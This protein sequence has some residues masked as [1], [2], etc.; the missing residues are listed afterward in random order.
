MDS[1]FINLNMSAP[2]EAPQA[3]Q[4]VNNE[5]CIL[6]QD[7]SESY[8]PAAYLRKHSPSAETMGEKDIFGRQHGGHPPKEF[9]GVHIINWEFQGNYALRPTFSD[10]HNSGLYSWA[11]LKMLDERQA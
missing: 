1:T 5:L 10:G 4:L 8:L 3:I 7:Q 11:Y 2:I 9:P 6:W